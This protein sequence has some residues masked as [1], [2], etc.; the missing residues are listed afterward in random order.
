[1]LLGLMLIGVGVIQG[2]WLLLIAWFGCNFFAV[3]IAHALGAHGIFGK[4]R[5]GSLPFW[6]WLAFFPLI[7]VSIAVWYGLRLVSGE[8]A[9]HAVTNDL[10]IGRRLVPSEVEGE[11]AN[12]IDLTAE[13][14]EPRAIRRSTGYICFPI[15]DGSAPDVES[16]REMI[17]RLRPGRTYIH[18]AQGHGRTGLFTLA[19]MLNSGAVKTVAQGLEKLKAVR[20]RVGLSA[21]Q[22]KCIEEFEAT[23]SRK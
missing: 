22:R 11:F 17:A 15:L 10:V 3:G 20:P 2:G 9:Q 21:V 19:L 18:C 4:R 6:S 1:M 5:D 13:F 8:S 12:Y 7:A 16:L 14:C 23:L